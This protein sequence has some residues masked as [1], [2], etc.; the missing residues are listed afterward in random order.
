MGIKCDEWMCANNG[1]SYCELGGDGEFLELR[2][3]GGEC[4]SYEPKG[5]T[6]DA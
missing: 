3:E 6:E 2:I 1:G 5:G 4:V